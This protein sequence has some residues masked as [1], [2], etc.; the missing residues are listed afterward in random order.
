MTDLVKSGN[1]EKI[2]VRASEVV[3]LRCHCKY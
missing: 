3:T 1:T 2:A